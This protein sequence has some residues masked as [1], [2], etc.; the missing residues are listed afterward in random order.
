MERKLSSS[1][2]ESVQGDVLPLRLLGV[3]PYSRA[4][5]AWECDG[6]CVQITSFAGADDADFTDG[7]LLTL[8]EPGEA[9][10]TAELEGEKYH[11]FVSV[12]E[13]KTAAS[14]KAL[15][16]YIGDLHDHTTMEHGR[17]AF[18]NRSGEFPI[19][20]IRQIRDEGKLDFAVVS[21]HGDLL[22]N[23][24][25]Y[26]GFADG[27]DAELTELVLF[28]GC[29][30]EITTLETDRYGVV[31]KNS[32]E[33]VTFNAAGYASTDTW[34]E[35]FDR[36]ADSPFAVCCLAH[37]QTLGSSTKGMWNFCLDKNNSPR[38]RQLVKLVEVGNGGDRSANLINEYVYSVALDNGFRVS[39]A[40]N[41]DSHGPQWGYDAFPGKTVIMAPEKSKEAF[42]DALCNQ[43]VY[44]SSSG[45]V[46]LFWSVC[47]VAAPGEVP[48]TDRY[49]FH[50]EV[51]SFHEDPGTVP[52]KCQ[53]ISDYGLCVKQ[54][55]NV[56]FSSFDFTVESD[57]A[58]YFYLRLMDREGRKTWSAP[59]WTGRAVDVASRAAM[60]PIG[61]EGFTA[62]DASSGADASRLLN[63]TP[64][65][66]WFSEGTSCSICIDMGKAN[67]ISGI[68][69]Y[70][71]ILERAKLA[72]QGISTSQVLS[73][74]PYEY[75]LST[76]LEGTVFEEK[77]SGLFRIFGEET[78]IPFA[79][80]SARFVKLEILS[81]VGANSGLPAYL[82]AN[83]T[84][85]EL[86][87]F[88]SAK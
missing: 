84:L 61:K 74:L 24:E 82:D 7:I 29:E 65:D 83:I 66:P 11:C 16:Y 21:D 70:H 88:K 85:A 6:D 53:V 42:L 71:R 50:V 67:A 59:I 13:M 25:F 19:D 9:V 28:P 57:T 45:N 37:P 26:R 79:E 58:R 68:G 32:G 18:Q 81:T 27:E 34:E 46:K 3:T 51:G 22:N 64:E 17:K 31:H 62:V 12:R 86:T 60:V 80:H 39:L 43:R 78:V 49:E 41:S 56:D 30:A 76:S 52:V 40:C 69:V 15:N 77:A 44:A 38:H 8:L 36:Y 1:R 33:I 35:F 47:G 23:R 48:L 2:I 14:G 54:I 10:V 73:Q 63:D 4:P 5:I 55:E 72:A 75:R 20:Y 87:V